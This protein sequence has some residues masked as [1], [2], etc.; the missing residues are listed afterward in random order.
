MSDLVETFIDYWRA[1]YERGNDIPVETLCL[2][3]ELLDT[4]RRRIEGFRGNLNT[5]KPS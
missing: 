2:H 1:A 5:D 4:L 3:V